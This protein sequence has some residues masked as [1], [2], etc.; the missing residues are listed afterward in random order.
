LS[1]AIEQRTKD[2]GQ[3][4]ILQAPVSAG[5]LIDKI[6]ILEIKLERITDVTKQANVRHELDLLSAVQAKSVPASPE[7]T[8]LAAEL[9]AVNERL[10][11]IED[12]IR[13]CETSGNFGDRFITLARSVYQ[14]NDHR[15]ALKRRI[16]D[17]LDS[18]I[19]EEKS[20]AGWENVV[21]NH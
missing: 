18:A 10:W 6:T 16:N 2:K 19:V 4:T 17:L 7:L 13:S 12:E 15:A 1:F 5:E 8:A 14:E 9:K 21:R 11:E 20:Y 3:R